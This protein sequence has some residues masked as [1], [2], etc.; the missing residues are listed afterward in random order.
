VQGL[1]FGVRPATDPDR[2]GWGFR[3]WRS[4][5]KDLARLLDLLLEALDAVSRG[6]ILRSRGGLVCKAH[7][8]CVSLNSRLDPAA[9]GS[10]QPIG[11]ALN[12]RT[13][14]SQKCEAV[15]RRARI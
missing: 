1:G 4:R 11:T 8:L 2:T 7:R 10:C 6:R 15:P 14:T 9:A 3:V 13:T 12:L 5:H